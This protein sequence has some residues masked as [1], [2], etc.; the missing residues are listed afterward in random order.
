LRPYFSDEQI[1][2]T[3]RARLERRRNLLAPRSLAFHAILDE[4][5]LL[6]V[7]GGPDAMRQQ[8]TNL[9]ETT[10]L[11]NV[12]VQVL[13]LSAGP[14]P[15]LNGSFSLFSFGAELDEFTY[16]EDQIGQTFEADPLTV[17]R[18]RT[19]FETLVKRSLTQRN[20]NAMIRRH[21]QALDQ[22]TIHD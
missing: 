17:Q 8:L 20:S 15:G 9:L 14:S 10:R 1:E 22:T 3:I 21:I 7:L 2:E 5:V 4:S 12:T 16:V 18:C 19:A 13:P 11:P 6:R